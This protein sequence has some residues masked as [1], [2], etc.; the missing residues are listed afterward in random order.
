MTTK[1]SQ[2]PPPGQHATGSHPGPAAGTLSGDTDMKTWSVFHHS[3]GRCD[4]V[5]RSIATKEAARETCAAA[6]AEE[7]AANRGSGHY[8]TT[9]A[10]DDADA[11]VI[12]E[13][14]DEESDDE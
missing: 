10:D 13:E 7:Q 12:D 9:D 1:K 11:V 8:Y 6:N 14:S 2:S 5:A 4:T 3:D